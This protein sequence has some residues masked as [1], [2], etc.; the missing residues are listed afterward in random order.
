LRV[1][2]QRLY[3]PF[4][5]ALLRS[6]LHGFMSGSTMLLTYTGRKSGKAYTTPVNYLRDGDTQ[7][8]VSSREHIWWKNLRGG[9]PVTARVRGQDMRGV[10]VAFEGEAA[11]GGLLTVLRR[12]PAYRRYFGVKLATDGTLKDPEAL[13]Q[14]AG[15]NAVVRIKDLVPER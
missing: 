8:V 13:A 15:S 9:A 1:R 3:N 2:W 4:V 11:E 5:V 7:L 10:G 12:V 14:V 6:P